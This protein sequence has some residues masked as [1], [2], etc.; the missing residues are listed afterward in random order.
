MWRMPDSTLDRL[1]LTAVVLLVAAVAK[2]LLTLL[3]RHSVALI[4]QPKAVDLGA[5]AAGVLVRAG[6]VNFERQ[7]QRMRTLG[8]LLN[9][10]AN[11]TIGGIAAFTALAIWGVPMG[12][13]LASAGIGGVAVGFGAQSLVRDYL[14]GIFMLSEDQFGVGDEVRIGVVTGIVQEV[15]L[16][17]TKVLD[18]DGVVW[19][20][21]NGE[22][23]TVG[24]A[25]QAATSAG[26]PGPTPR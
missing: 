17:V 15:G 6:G 8:S 10:I 3:I 14:T 9:N 26:G 12:P 24:N 13:L 2:L 4:T 5:R 23:T 19:Y 20:I 18:A 7:A 22:M 25:T 21:R 1:I 16:R 11:V